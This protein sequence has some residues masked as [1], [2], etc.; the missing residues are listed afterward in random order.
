MGQRKWNGREQRSRWKPPPKTK[1]LE[2]KCECATGQERVGEAE[3]DGSKCSSA[4]PWRGDPP[5]IVFTATV[6]LPKGTVAIPNAP[7]ATCLINHHHNGQILTD[8]GEDTT[9]AS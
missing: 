2:Q 4:I 6:C 7:T 8:Q 5:Y 3:S 1:S 9:S